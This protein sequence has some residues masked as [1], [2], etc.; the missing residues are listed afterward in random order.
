MNSDMWKLLGA[1]A[2]VLAAAMAVSMY[3]DLKRYIKIERM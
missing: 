1:V 2:V 3:P